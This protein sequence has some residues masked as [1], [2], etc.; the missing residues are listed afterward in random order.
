MWGDVRYALRMMG[1]SPG[2]TAVAV[3]SLALGIGA[4]TA[5]FSLMYTVMLRRL[6]VEHPEQLVELLHRLPRE[7]H[8]ANSFTRQAWQELRENNR[9]LSALM[10]AA[11]ASFDV[12]GEGLETERVDGAYV[13]GDFFAAL[14]MKA[15]LGRLT[16]AEDDRAGDARS[17]VAVVSWWWWKSRLQGDRGVLGKRIFVQDVPATIVGVAPR[18]FEA[19]QSG[20][21]QD[22]WLP[23]AASSARGISGDMPVQLVWRL[24]RGVPLEQ[25]HAEL[26]VLDHRLAM[27]QSRAGTNPYASELVLD[28]EPAGAGLT[29][30]LREQY[31]RPLAALPLRRR[32]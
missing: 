28:L 32:R 3:L 17:A 29:S 6:P 7:G 4:N 20:S 14:G 27:E 9:V 13:A 15:A 19:W 2:F 8:Q 30:R 23:L 18:G 31:G 22:V 5:I 12:R 10:A 26:S 11:P 16:G 1:R 25:A 24:K 21:H